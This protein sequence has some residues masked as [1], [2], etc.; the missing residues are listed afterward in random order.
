MKKQYTLFPIIILLIL[1][2]AGRSVRS[3]T[4]AGEVFNPDDLVLWAFSD[5]QPRNEKERESFEIAVDDISAMKNIDA[6][7]CAGDIVQYGKEFRAVE[8]YK[9]FYSTFKKSGIKKIF[10]VAG[11]HDA[12]NIDAYLEATGKPLHYAVRYGNLLIIFLS[13][14]K[15]SS[16]TDISDGAF[17]WWKNLIETN[18]DRNIITMTHSQLGGSGFFYNMI[19]YRNVQGSE[20]FTEVLAKEKVELWLFGHTHMPSSTG[21]S[22]RQIHSLNDTVFMNVSAIREDYL[23]SSTESRIIILKKGSDEMTVKIRLHRDREFKSCLEQKIKLKSKFEY[24]G[25]EPVMIVYKEEQE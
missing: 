4:A 10:E 20:R 7:I 9:W 8:D 11:N 21:L 13:D 2:C 25:K 24:D 6:A 18:R 23:L 12:R 3:G 1:S 17:K 14:E 22:K 15:D 5:I 19:S 16:G